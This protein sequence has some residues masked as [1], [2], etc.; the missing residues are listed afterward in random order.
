M[1]GNKLLEELKADETMYREMVRLCKADLDKMGARGELFTAQKLIDYNE[2]L[3]RLTTII[4]V[5][6]LV[7]KLICEEKP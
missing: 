7:L 5:R 4:Y 6:D 1:D 2:H 3:T